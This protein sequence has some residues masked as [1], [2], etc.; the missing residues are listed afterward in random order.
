MTKKWMA[1]GLVAALCGAVQAEPIRTALTKENRLPR[2][3]EAEV[4]STFYYYDLE[5]GEQT[6]AIPYMRYTL[7]KDFSVFATLPYLQ[8]DP[9][10]GSSE[11]GIGDA[12][13][14]FEFVTYEDLFG[15]PWI[16]P[17]AEVIFDTGDEDKGLGQ[18]EIQYR[19]GVAAGT[20]VNRVFH[21]AADARYLVLNDEDDVASI[22]GSI[23]WDLDEDFSLMAE[24]ELSREEGDDEIGEDANHPIIFLGGM[25]YRVTPNFHITLQG[26][27][28][29]NIDIDAIIRGKLAYTF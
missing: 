5:A 18:G 25:H 26:G 23:V 21:F 12:S 11:S 1:I 8:N 16:M 4:G 3:Y 2:L 7:F 6:A 22:A 17:H 10:F 15:Y 29:K 24:M 27:T 14:G 19:V 13:L 9:E 28:A 20:T